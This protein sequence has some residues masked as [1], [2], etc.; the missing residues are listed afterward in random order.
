MTDSVFEIVTYT[1][2]DI[3]QAEPARKKAYEALMHYPGF[4][5]WTRYATAEQDRSFV[6][7][8]AWKTLSDAQSAQQVFLKDPN[9][10]DFIAVIDT[11]LAMSHVKKVPW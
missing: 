3:E 9:M 4:I 11:V 1:V 10:A 6:D 5:S 2:K 8:V 7:Q